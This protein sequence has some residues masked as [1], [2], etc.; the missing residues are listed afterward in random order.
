VEKDVRKNPLPWVNET[1]AF[2]EPL[3]RCQLFPWREREK[4]EI[5]EN[6]GQ[7]G[8]MEVSSSVTEQNSLLYSHWANLSNHCSQW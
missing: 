5:G 2:Q 4:V 1:L 3:H 7:S 8:G 6:S